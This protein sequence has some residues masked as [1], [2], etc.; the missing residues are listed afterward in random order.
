MNI[1]L[2][3][4]YI[5]LDRVE[6]LNKESVILQLLYF[7]YDLVKT[8]SHID[9]VHISCVIPEP[10]SCLFY[11]LCGISPEKFPI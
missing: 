4:Q 1:V 3:L 8:H 5:S 6:K 7:D 11:P 2:L 10:C 9:T